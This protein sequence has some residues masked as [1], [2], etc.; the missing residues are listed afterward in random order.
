MVVKYEYL[1]TQPATLLALVGMLVLGAFTVQVDLRNAEFLGTLVKLVHLTAF[2]V[3]LGTQAWVTF[4]AGERDGRLICIFKQH[5]ITVPRYHNVPNTVTEEFLS[6]PGKVVSQVFCFR[7][8]SNWF[9]LG[10]VCP[11]ASRS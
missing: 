9:R 6:R 10:D 4:F 5:R 3:W 8:D 2:S 1:F 7:H 11:G